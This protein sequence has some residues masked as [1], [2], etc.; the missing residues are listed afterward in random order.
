[1][2]NKEFLQAK[3]DS[4]NPFESHANVW[5]IPVKYSQLLNLDGLRVFLDRKLAQ[6]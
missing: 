4:L 6:K 2:K 1:M 3:I 5:W